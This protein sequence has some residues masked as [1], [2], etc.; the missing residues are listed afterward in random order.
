MIEKI[1]SFSLRQKF[2]VIF[3]SLLMAAWGIASF[4]NISIEAFPDVTDTTVQVITQYA[5]KASE[6][7]EKQVTL[8]IETQLNG[9][10]HASQ[11]RSQ[12]LAGLS[13]INV[14]FDDAVDMY[15]ARQQVIERLQSAELPTGAQTEL[16]P[17]STPI[18]E[19]YRYTLES[20]DHSPMEL[21]TLQDW[22]ME[23][24]LKSVPGVA[25]VVSFGGEV[26]QFQ[27]QVDPLKLRSYGLTLKDIFDGLASSNQN[28]GGGYLR[29]N[30]EQFIVRGIGLLA[31]VSDIQ[32]TVIKAVNGVPIRVEDIGH[33]QVGPAVRQGIVG[34]NNKPEVVEGIVLMRRGENPSKVL[35][36]IRD[37]LKE[38]QHDLPRGV[39]IKPVYDRQILIDRALENVK[40]T[41]LFGI[42]LVFVILMLFTGEWTL[43]T[44]VTVIIPLA[45][46]FAF[47]LMK[48]RGIAANLM[49]LGAI[50]FGIIIDGSVV[51][52]ESIFVAL[53]HYPNFTNNIPY[54][55]R[56]GAAVGKPILFSKAIIILTLLPLYAL[57]RVEGRLFTPMALT[58][59]FA[60]IG[61]LIFTLT[62]VPVLCS[63]LLKKDVK[64]KDIWLI[65]K[66]DEL[67]T[68]VLQWSLD[69]RKTVLTIAVACLGASL[70]LV[71]FLGT[72][73]MPE[74]DEGAIW[75]RATM[76]ISIA[77]EDAQAIVPKITEVIRHFP[78]VKTTVSQIGRPEDATDP[79]LQNNTEIFVDLIPKG[80]WGM[81]KE[82]LIDKL[83]EKLEK[84]FPGIA[85]NFS[86]PIQDNVDEAISGVKGQVAIKLFGPDLKVLIAKTKEISKLVNKIKGVND[87]FVDQLT[88]QPQLAIQ[89]DRDLASRYG[90]RVQDVQDVIE[91]ALAGKMATQYVEAER[92]F[93]LVVRLQPEYRQ[94]IA[95]IKNLQVDSSDGKQHI[96]IGEIA[97][98]KELIGAPIIYR[99]NNQRRAAVRL[100]VRDRDM[101]GLVAEAQKVVSQKIK[102]PDGYNIIWSG[103]FE[104]QQ[105]AMGRLFSIMP[106]SLLMIVV[107]LFIAFGSMKNA[108]LILLNV[109][110]AAIGGILGLFFLHIHLSVSALVG[111]IALF[112]VSVQNGVILV[113]IFNKLRQ[114]GNNLRDSIVLGVKER[115]RPVIMTA[116]LASM[117]LVPA[118]I[119][120]GTGSET[121][122]PLAIVII[123]GL[124]SATLLVLVVLPTLY[125]WFEREEV[126]F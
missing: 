79:N 2:L 46:L 30:D 34:K 24:R 105:R 47:I 50:D 104:S 71:P 52:V 5:G 102:L 40:E 70:L 80:K 93:D 12:S 25:D 59:S 16:G 60:L 18:G 57:Q 68:P 123:F 39:K 88:G 97:S 64:E 56:S 29:I 96:P 55:I 3:V 27:V 54:I 85:F 119:S 43:A 14:I 1:I 87:L 7:I 125:G 106:I 74:V 36:A 45:L 76:P 73:F 15:F 63:L 111:F 75:V 81:N 72:E 20:N 126:E 77:L 121:Q 82:Q 33:V 83:D 86:Q 8:P 19:L 37:K 21:R 66:I 94:D 101:G 32:N 44:I 113:S 69:N 28:T 92:R 107:L 58:I 38:L 4:L 31:S 42:V 95:A 65:K 115:L 91:T 103:Q 17:M 117:G 22:F 67:Y 10:P 49:S 114:E 48:S 35:E 110:F 9:L 41:I 23:R 26:K 100:N 116:M 78:Q 90:I 109:P 53:A 89:I 84:N 122:K 11:I 124:I 99:E 112:G 108:I 51:M 6:E 62:L 13:V 61:A 118:A 120:S 98:F